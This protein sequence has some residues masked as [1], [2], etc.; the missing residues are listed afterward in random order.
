MYYLEEQLR[1][2]ELKMLAA[3]T[4]NVA[5]VDW[6]SLFALL[7]RIFHFL[8]GDS[9]HEGQFLSVFQEPLHLREVQFS[10]CSWT[11]ISSLS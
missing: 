2:L 4:F 7:S 6:K 5:L 3:T 11:I 10:L 8:P 9:F 1:R